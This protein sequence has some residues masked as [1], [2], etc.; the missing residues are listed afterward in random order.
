MCHE[1]ASGNHVSQQLFLNEEEED[2]DYCAT[3]A[4][5]LN[6]RRKAGVKKEKPY[7]S[8]LNKSAAQEPEIAVI[9]DQ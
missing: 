8:V 9:H 4:T 5:E 1:M 6:N 7:K 2:D 3:N